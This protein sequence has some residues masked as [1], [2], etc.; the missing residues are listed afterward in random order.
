MN[1]TTFLSIAGS[2]PSGGAGIQADLKTATALGTYGMTA[3]TAITAQ[4]TQGVTGFSAVPPELLESQLEAVLSDIR[5]MATKTGMLPDARSIAVTA[6]MIE[7]YELR[8]VVVDPVLIATSGDAL[9]DGDTMLA[10]KQLLFPHALLITP[11][12]EE[13]EKLTGM[14]I[15][16]KEDA[17]ECAR[18]LRAETGCANVLIK[19]GHGTGELLSD[20]LLTADEVSIIEHAR[21]ETRNT[22]G[23]G[24]TLSSAIACHL[25]KGHKLIEAVS[26]SIN[27]LWWAIHTGAEMNIGHG[28]GPVNHL[29]EILN[30]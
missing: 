9:S 17:I 6:S 8:N 25:A 11:N 26:M 24:C 3:I 13:A 7:H 28:H 23:T 21:V 1:Y 19:G 12:L 20:I 29:Y 30:D 22:H 4:N 18:S 2:D 14:K 27:W 16:G 10:L 15:A 5:P